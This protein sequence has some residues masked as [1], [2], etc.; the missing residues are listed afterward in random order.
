MK[1]FIGALIVLLMGMT[2]CPV[3]ALQF[4]LRS[5]AATAEISSQTSFEETITAEDN[6]VGSVGFTFRGG[7]PHALHALAFS[8]FDE[9][10]NLLHQSERMVEKPVSPYEEVILGF[11]VQS[12]SKGKTYR[13]RLDAL[14]ETLPA[15]QRIRLFSDLPTAQAAQEIK[16]IWSQKWNE[17]R[18]FWQGYGALLL[19]TAIAYISA[20]RTK[21][22]L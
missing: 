14:G 6:F 21:R 9:E 15:P 3:Q 4:P 1:Y 20:A 10:G 18:V 7:I 8:L 17:Q 11:P 19:L 2:A 13:V 16:N 12:E 22:K 5:F